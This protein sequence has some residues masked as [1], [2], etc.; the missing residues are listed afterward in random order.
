MDSFERV[1]YRRTEYFKQMND[2]LE[3]KSRTQLVNAKITYAVELQ[4]VMREL[5][6][7]ASGH[8]MELIIIALIA[9]EATLVNELMVYSSMMETNRLDVGIHSRRSRNLEDDHRKTLSST[10]RGS[11]TSSHQSLIHF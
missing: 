5:L 11:L 4:S 1:A 7:E 2:A 10:F 8:R 9:F 3:I 6:T